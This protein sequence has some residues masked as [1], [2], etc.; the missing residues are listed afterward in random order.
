M[1]DSEGNRLKEGLDTLQGKI[2]ETDNRYADAV[3]QFE[4]KLK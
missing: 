1:F 4:E 2:K 3:L